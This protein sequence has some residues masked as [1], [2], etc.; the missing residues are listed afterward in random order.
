[1]RAGGSAT[2]IACLALAAARVAT[3]GRAAADR[4]L[5]AEDLD[6]GRVVSALAEALAAAVGAGVGGRAG[7][8]ALEV[9]A[10]GGAP[11]LAGCAGPAPLRRQKCVA[12]PIPA[13]SSRAHAPASINRRGP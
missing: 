13:T 4:R 7:G 1:M 5:P 10:E 3:E 8:C 12:T 2:A 6:T 9:A 11:V